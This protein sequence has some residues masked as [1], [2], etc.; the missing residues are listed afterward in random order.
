MKILYALQATGNGHIS[1]AQTL[2]P[3]FSKSS[4]VDVLI[5]GT[6]YDIS[7]N[8]PVKFR[9]TGLSFIFGKDG[10][11]DL[12]K[13]IFKILFYCSYFNFSELNKLRP[14]EHNKPVF[15]LI[16]LIRPRHPSMPR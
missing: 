10:R 4:Q 14:F 5:S 3:L 11:V 12:L 7:L 13:T 2:I 8:L 16:Y 9:F 1:R 15:P 6:S